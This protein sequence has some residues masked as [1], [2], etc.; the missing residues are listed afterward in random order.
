MR[1]SVYFLYFFICIIR[2][3]RIIWINIFLSDNMTWRMIL[4][5]VFLF[6]C[7][8]RL[9]S[10]KSSRVWAR[11]WI[12]SRQFFVLV[13]VAAWV[14]V[15][16]VVGTVIVRKLLKWF[17]SNSCW[18]FA[19]ESL[20]A[21]SSSTSAAHINIYTHTHTESIASFCRIRSHKFFPTEIKSLKVTKI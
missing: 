4:K 8:F 6:V 21:W 20:N 7:V 12:R 19:C 18:L 11:F 16:V 3:V 17:L 14:V 2:K 15:V 1:L 5:F 13:V 9:P 10:I